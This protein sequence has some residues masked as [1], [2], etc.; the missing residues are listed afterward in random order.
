MTKKEKRQQE[1]KKIKSLSKGDRIEYLWMYYKIWLLVA[2]LAAG[3]ACLGFQMYRGMHE[4]VIV[5]VAIV[6][7]GG[8]NT[9][10]MEEGF[11]EYAGIKRKNDVV[12]IWSNI[13]EESK[14]MSSR[15]ALTTLIGADAVDVII[16]PEDVFQEYNAQGGFVSME[17]I[18]AESLE[19]D[20]LQGEQ[21][22]VVIEDSEFLKNIGGIPYKKAYVGMLINAQHQEGAALFIKYLLKMK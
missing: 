13:S 19:I 1:L 9:G 4:N 21:N 8:I 5:N 2:L 11:K 6:G 14:S 12:R 15:T 16:C 3:G 18:L 10:E 7:G 20:A 22:T 17:E